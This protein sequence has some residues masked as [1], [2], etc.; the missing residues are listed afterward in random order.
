M[1]DILGYDCDGEFFYNL[2]HDEL[3]EQL[4]AIIKKINQRS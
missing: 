4:N 3:K 2:D 1:D